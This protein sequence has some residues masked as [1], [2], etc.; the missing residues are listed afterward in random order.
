MPKK[1]DYHLLQLAS[2]INSSL[3]I[4]TVLDRAMVA[5]EEA[6]DAEASAIFEVDVDKGDLF[7]RLA[8]GQK[9]EKVKR[10]R[11]RMGEGVAGW[12]AQTGQS[13]IVPEADADS[14]FNPNVDAHSG[15]DTRS[16][17]CVPLQHQGR[18]VGVVQ[19]LNKRASKEFDQEDLEILN[20]LAQ[21]IAVALANAQ[22]YKNLV[23]VSQQV[24]K[25]L[26][27]TTELRDPYTAGHQRRVA[28]LAVAIARE[29]GLSQGK[30]EVLRI[31]CILHD[32]GKITVPTEILSKPGRLNQL[33]LNLVK[34]HVR[35]GYE[36]LKEIDF[37]REIDDIVRQHHERLDGSGYPAGLKGDEITL[38]ARIIAVADVVEAVTFH[39]PYRPGRGKEKALEEI[40]KDRGKGLDP[41]VVDACCSVFRKGFEFEE[42]A[43]PISLNIP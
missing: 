32:I 21:H 39:R 18:L 9:A 26:S 17:V 20:L 28:E 37:P 24:L 7:F 16:I 42:T 15:F 13:I 1:I 23:V 33:E 41:I 36:I 5:I 25:T 4:E 11:I 38:E 22:T 27:M 34:S 19:V 3:D 6:L 8:R 40:T 43:P 29:L 14:R 30:K 35:A 31:A 10:L 2:Q 12:V